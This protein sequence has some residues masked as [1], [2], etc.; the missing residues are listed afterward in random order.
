MA[1]PFL[2]QIELFPYTFA[3]KG[4]AA[5]QGQYL[6]IQ[7]YTALFSLL[8][9]T[10]GGNG[11]SNFGLPNLQG[12]VTVAQ[13]QGPGLVNYDLGETAG[14]QPVGLN[15]NQLGAHNHSVNANVNKGDTV[16]PTNALLASGPTTG[17]PGREDKTNL[18]TA[19]ASPS[20]ALLSAA[21]SLTGGNG[22]HNNL[23]P[24][25]TLGYYIALTGIFPPRP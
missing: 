10:Y 22:S 17:Q 15:A 23:Q 1:E 19:A 12:R 24:Y 9:T 13:G 5:C 11:T 16:L 25:L 6:S 18:Y 8:G 2:G 20:T 4:W 21:I 14:A 3:P 7:Q